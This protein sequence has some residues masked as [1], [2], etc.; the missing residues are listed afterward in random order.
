MPELTTATVSATLVGLWT[1]FVAIPHVMTYG[2]T[3]RRAPLELGCHAAPDIP[4]TPEQASRVMQ[5]LIDCDISTCDRKRAAYWVWV[6]S[7]H[8][9]A[10]AGIER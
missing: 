3:W 7:G 8:A 2:F 4:F 10:A 5:V 9:T 1:I 6:D